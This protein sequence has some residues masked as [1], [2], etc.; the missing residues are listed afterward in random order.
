MRA[1]P[2]RLLVKRVHEQS[3]HASRR[4]R[5]SDVVEGKPLLFLDPRSGRSRRTE[6]FLVLVLQWRHSHDAFRLYRID[7]TARLDLARTF[8]TDL[9]PTLLFVEDKRVKARL[10]QP[11]GCKGRHRTPR[12][13]ALL[14]ADGV[15]GR[16]RPRLRPARTAAAAH[17][18]RSHP[19]NRPC[20]ANSVCLGSS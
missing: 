10:E 15:L 5:A 3:E 16:R 6:G 2:G 7:A 20:N 9:V 11:R 8:L 13:V 1:L 19:Q 4:A 17:R 12:T 14:T 18:T